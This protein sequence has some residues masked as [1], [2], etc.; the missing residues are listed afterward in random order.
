MTSTEARARA[1]MRAI[2]GTVQGA[3][4]LRLTSA[5]A[6]ATADDEV[7]LHEQ[8]PRPLT[9]APAACRATTWPL[10]R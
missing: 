2:A 6:P 7:G 9:S 4:P 5:A 1:A 8:G 3:P 10:T